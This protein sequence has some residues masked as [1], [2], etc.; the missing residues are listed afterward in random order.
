M[1][2][3][4][5]KH[6]S[7]I[8]DLAMNDGKFDEFLGDRDRKM[9][10]LSV[11]VEKFIPIS[12]YATDNIYQ[13][14]LIKNYQKKNET[15]ALAKFDSEDDAREFIIKQLIVLQPELTNR[16]RILID[17]GETL[18]VIEK[19]CQNKDDEFRKDV[20]ETMRCRLSLVSEESDSTIEDPF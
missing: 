19:Y 18:S 7:A 6:A 11:K 1:I 14:S 15:L 16:G 13:V 12:P 9:N 5:K 3:M 10:F 20:L 2:L 4:D 8:A 17:L